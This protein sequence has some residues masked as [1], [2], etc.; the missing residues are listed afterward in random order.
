MKD[1]NKTA[2]WVGQAKLKPLY[3]YDCFKVK[4]VVDDA[5]DSSTS[6]TFE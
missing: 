2:H 5:Q 4:Q 6:T 1:N 3:T